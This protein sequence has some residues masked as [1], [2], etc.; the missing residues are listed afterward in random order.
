M[1]SLPDLLRR[2]RRVWVPPGAALAHVAPPV[3]VSAR[4]RAELQPVLDAIA[5]TQQRAAK[6]RADA[7]SKAAALVDAAERQ[8]AEEI[9]K[10]E[11]EAPAAR[12]AAAERKW[13][14]VEVEIAAALKAAQAE[15][16][17]IEAGSRQRLP[18]LVENVRTC[19]ASG[20]C[21]ES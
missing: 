10:A 15:A 6:I 14:A 12:S 20:R 16:A 18:E 8:A 9:R 21:L 4:L 17:R 2:F 7:A 13:Q 19:V 1:I 5:V 3:D 11:A